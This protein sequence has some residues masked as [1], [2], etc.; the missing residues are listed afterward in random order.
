[1]EQ[2]VKIEA[3]LTGDPAELYA[4]L[5]AVFEEK[6]GTSLS[7]MN[8]ALLQTGVIH[9]L[10]PV[11][12]RLGRGE[13]ILGGIQHGWVGVTQGVDYFALDAVGVC[14]TAS[15]GADD[16]NVELRVWRLGAGACCQAGGSSEAETDKG[17]SGVINFGS[18]EF[19]LKLL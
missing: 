9:H 14:S 3:T 8:R 2:L 1:M 5:L 7:E 4:S 15:P 19:S 6:S 18:H 11:A 10:T 16:G 13:A 12:G 17:A